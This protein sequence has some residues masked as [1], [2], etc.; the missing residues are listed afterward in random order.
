MA[1][2]RNPYR[3]GTASHAR[4]R[5]ARLK[6]R[7]TLAAANAARA[8]SPETR[9]R[10]RQRASA[11]HRALRKIE[12][13]AEFRSRLNERERSDF[14]RLSILQQEQMLQLAGA[15]PDH[16]PADIPDPF[17]GPRRS[18]S[19]RLYYSTRA[20]IRLHAVA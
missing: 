8:K 12:Q 19:W 5:A 6:S 11:A 9:R 14:D 18:L 20:G 4:V 10:A 2:Q 3:P 17:T 13:R 16:V 1:R 7:A 15:F